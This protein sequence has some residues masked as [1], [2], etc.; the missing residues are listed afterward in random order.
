M[1]IEAFDVSAEEQSKI[2]AKSEGHFLDFKSKDISPAKLSRSLSAFANA[3]GGELFVGVAELNSRFI[4][5]GFATPEDANAIIQV[6]GDIFPL[7]DG[8][9]MRFL[10]CVDAGYVLYI[11]VRKSSQITKTTDGSIYIR[12]SAQNR[13]VTTDQERE[14]LRLDKGISSFETQTISV[15]PEFITNSA[16]IIGFALEIVPHQEPEK[17]LRMQQLIVNNLPTV[18]GV[19]LFADEPQALLPKRCGIKIYRYSSSADEGTRETLDGVPIT[20]EGCAYAQ[21]YD[22]VARTKRVIETVR[23]MT[24]EG[25][26]NVTYPEETLHEIITNAVIHRDYSIT[27]DVHIRIY[28][29]RVEIESPGRLPGHVTPENILDTRFARN[30][31][32]VRIINKFPNPPN[33]DVG[34]GLNTAFR[35]MKQL[36]LK[37]PI[38]SQ[39]EGSVVVSIR[40]EKLGS[41]EDLIM[42]FLD[43]HP[44]INNKQ[45]RE[46][47]V[48]REDW[49]VRS[50]FGSMERAGLIE[51]VEGSRTS[52]TAYRK[53]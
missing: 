32:I 35:A 25:L 18:A 20:I 44:S 33:K 45:A 52:N 30:G 13:P 38:I 48:I 3:D 31:S 43:T 22:A 12:R 16:A 41:A 40:H 28:D 15:D 26:V 7:T 36:Q 46:I 29:N 23:R 53:K 2:L 14:R 19:V 9:V 39:R 8:V 34:E 17:W 27:D 24:P 42:R 37:E 11:D 47:C 51:K 21:I 50:I 5:D 49:R 6:V 4:W 1:S 10:R